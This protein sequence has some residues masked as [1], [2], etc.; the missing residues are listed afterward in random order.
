MPRRVCLGAAPAR[1]LLM[2][3]RQKEASAMSNQ[4]TQ[5]QNSAEKARGMMEKL[6]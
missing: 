6:Q 4:S 1:I 5:L 2:P 3:D